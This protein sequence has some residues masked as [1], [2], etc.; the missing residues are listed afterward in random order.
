MSDKNSGFLA[1][2]N[3]LRTAL[4]ISSDALLAERL[5]LKYSAWSMRK[6]RGTL[7]TQEIDALINAEGLN[8]EFIYDGKG[9]VHLDVDGESWSDGFQKRLAQSLRL[10][11]YIGVLIPEGHSRAQLK[12]IATGKTEP[13]AK[14]LRDM[15]RCLALD[16][17]WLVCGDTDAA[18]DRDERALVAAYRKAPTV[19]KEF[20]RHASG[21]AGNITASSPAPPAPEVDLVADYKSNQKPKGKAK[22]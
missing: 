7:P 10:E 22:S 8:P 13:P 19:G 15:R 11:N 12:S 9:P 16:L 1:I 5:G 2:A 3:R 14:L 21:M 18:L 20:I 6:S 4:D 17:N